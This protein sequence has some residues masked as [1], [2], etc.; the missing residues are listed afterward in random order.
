VEKPPPVKI[1]AP[2]APVIE[3]VERKADAEITAEDLNKL[4]KMIKASEG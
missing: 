2:P 1:A 4:E 3:F